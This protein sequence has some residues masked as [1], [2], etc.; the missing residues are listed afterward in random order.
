MRRVVKN[1]AP[2]VAKGE[3]G[4]IRE[5]GRI[6]QQRTQ[7]TEDV[8]Y[9]WGGVR[10]AHDIDIRARAGRRYRHRRYPVVTAI[11]HA[12]GRAGLESDQSGTLPS[13]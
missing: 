13:S 6:E 3:T 10:I 7:N 4:R 8:G 2:C 12:E 9:G 11:S 1:V 5:G